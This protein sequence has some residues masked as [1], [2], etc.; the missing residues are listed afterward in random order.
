MATLLE[1]PSIESQIFPSIE[2]MYSSTIGFQRCIGDSVKVSWRALPTVLTKEELLDKAFSRAKKSA[3]RVDDSDRVFR[4]RKQMNRM[5]Q[6]AADIL[7][8][9]LIETVNTWP[10]LD[11]SPQFDVSMIDACVG[12]DDYRHHLSMLQWT[13]NQITKISQQNSKKVTRTGRIELMHEARREAYGRISSLMGRVERSLEWLGNARDTLKKLPNIDPL[14]P[15]IVVCGAPNVGKSAFISALSSGKMEVNH[16]PFTTKRIHVG[17]F[18]FRRLQ[19]QI[20]D[21][22]GL[23]DRPMENRNQIEMQAIS[24]LEHLG[25]LVLF[26]IDDS[27][28]CGTSVEEQQ[29]L[30]DEVSKLLPGTELVII[31]TKADIHETQPLNWQEVK[32]A[33]KEYIDGGEEIIA[34]IPLLID[35]NDNITISAQENV[36]LEALKMEIVRFIKESQ[37]PEDKMKLPEGWYRSD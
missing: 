18:T 27:E 12:C 17:H 35:S 26:L 24:A 32:D 10:S 3:D 13:A 30:L 1:P 14:S 22:P 29:N 20:V 11:Q 5:I 4:V 16:Y 36:G 6:T 21:T 15:C 19:Y 31:S 8:T 7:S 28:E 9:S 37:D 2:G 33:E 25:S 34:D 23:L